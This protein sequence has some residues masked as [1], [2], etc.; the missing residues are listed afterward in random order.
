[1]CGQA[2]PCPPA[3]DEAARDGSAVL[4]PADRF[5]V[6]VD[7]ATGE[8]AAYVLTEGHADDAAQVPDLLRPPE[9]DIASLTADGAY[10]GDPVYRTAAAHQPGRPP[11][12]VIR[13]ALLPP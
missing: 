6:G 9:G 5:A 4:P 3:M 10:D 1:M 12:V 7:A 8:I 13:L 2:R 11:D